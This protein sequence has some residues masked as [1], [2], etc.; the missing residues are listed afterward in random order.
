MIS[1]KIN[2]EE[3]DCALLQSPKKTDTHTNLSTI[4]VIRSFVYTFVI[5]SLKTQDD[6]IDEKWLLFWF[7]LEHV[8]KDL[9][10]NFESLQY[11]G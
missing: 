3:S 1:H 2:A 4:R 9:C 10:K 8:K 5:I 11:L 6:I 7:R